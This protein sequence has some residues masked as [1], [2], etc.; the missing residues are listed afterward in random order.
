MEA[1]GKQEENHLYYF[2]ASLGQFPE[3]SNIQQ[4]Q[5]NITI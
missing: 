4:Q 1:V 5:N 3:V 2:D